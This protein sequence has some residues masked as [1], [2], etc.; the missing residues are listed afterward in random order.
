MILRPV[1]VVALFLTV[2]GSNA[3]HLRG[4]RRGPQ[5][6]T[7]KLKTE[8]S[9]VDDGA[10]RDDTDATTNPTLPTEPATTSPPPVTTASGA[11]SS[12][13]CQCFTLC[14]QC[15]IQQVDNAQCRDACSYANDPDCV[16]LCSA[17]LQG[18]EVVR[19]DTNTNPSLPPETTDTPQTGTTSP[20]PATT[21]TPATTTATPATSPPSTGTCL[22]T[23]YCKMCN[24]QGI[25]S[26]PCQVACTYSTH[27]DCENLCKIYLD[28]LDTSPGDDRD[29][30]GTNPPLPG[31]ATCLCV[32]ICEGCT[33][34]G[35]KTADCKTVCAY[36]DLSNDECTTLC[37]AALHIDEYGYYIP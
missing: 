37:N 18:L 9:K 33:D 27:A 5:K 8:K 13:T 35:S 12:S 1:V 3:E 34:R 6:Q 4:V 20:P 22:C 26:E 14:H 7:R 25:D 23:D 31:D 15:Y 24:D 11:T 28:D 36:A 29:D 32:G 21:A 2:V 30:S 16:N 10:I 17:F 19:D